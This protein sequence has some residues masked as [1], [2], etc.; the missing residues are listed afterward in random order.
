M[1]FAI[2]LLF[3]ACWPG[4][5]SVAIAA[6]AAKRDLTPLAASK[7]ELVPF[8]TSPF[9]YH[10]EVP[11]TG[12]PFLDVTDGDR[13][14][15][16]SARL[17]GTY[18]ED[19]TYSD[20]RVLLHIPKGFDARRPALIVLFLHGNETILSRDVR[21]RQ[22]V[23]RQITQSGLN[24]ALVAP[25]FAVNASDSSAG[26]F[27]EPGL[28]AKFLQEA[29]QRLAQL[30]G[31]E[32]ARGAFAA[33]PV[34]I[35]AYSGGYYPAAFIL[36]RGGAEERV[37]GLVLFDSLYGE[38]EK[39][40]DWLAKRPAAFFASAYGKSAHDENEAF[41]RLLKERGLHFHKA[42]PRTLARGSVAFIAVDD[43]IKH[44]DFMTEAWV[45]DPLKVILR[46]I[47]G[48]SRVGKK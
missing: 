25:Q 40:A 22:E 23:P 26:R 7:T 9:P 8:D 29:G 18:W 44:E 42:L 14:G 2:L 24:A 10:G 48:F 30:H 35:A 27:W 21:T 47:G 17:G 5:A 33:A 31:D 41:Q 43:E 38:Q 20:R 11:G 45:K 1:F 6:P 15:H 36:H 32:R 34:V 39:F 12:R 3:A 28:F 13:R 16:F 19:E 37:R 4:D 46:R